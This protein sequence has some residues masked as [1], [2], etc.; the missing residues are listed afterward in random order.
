MFGSL[1]E[2]EDPRWG[3]PEQNWLNCLADDLE[4]FGATHGSTEGEQRTFGVDRAVWKLAAKKGN[5]IPW[6]QG[7]IDGAKRFMVPW[8]QDE[9]QASR[10]RAA[11]REE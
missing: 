7:V 2:G 3:R 6:H 11:K 8:H 10:R 5:G 1:A 9:E 4:E